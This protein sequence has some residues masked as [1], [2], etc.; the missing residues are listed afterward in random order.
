MAELLVAQR[1]PVSGGA[2][3]S[4][5]RSW[6]F[7][8]D[9]VHL[10][11]GAS[12]QAPDDFSYL[13]D[14]ATVDSPSVVSIGRQI[15]ASQG[16]SFATKSSLRRDPFARLACELRLEI[17]CLLPSLSVKATMLV[18]RSMGEVPFGRRY[19]LSRFRLPEYSHIPEVRLLPPSDNA[20]SP[21]VNLQRFYTEGRY[22]NRRRWLVIQSCH[23]LVQKLLQ[24]RNILGLLTNP[25]IP[26]DVLCNRYLSICEDP[27]AQWRA[28]NK[29]NKWRSL[30]IFDDQTQISR[31][32]KIS[33]S[34]TKS[35]E[36]KLL[37]GIEFQFTQ[38]KLALGFMER[39]SELV[40]DL[41]GESLQKYGALRVRASRFG[42]LSVCSAT[43]VMDDA[44][45]ELYRDTT[46]GADGRKWGGALFPARGNPDPWLPGR[47]EIRGFQ[48]E[49]TVVRSLSRREDYSTD[50]LQDNRIVSLGLLESKTAPRNAADRRIDNLFRKTFVK[51]G[52][53]W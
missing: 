14:F 4:I 6:Y 27:F 48:A 41:V 53:E 47:N 2:Y 31:C 18:S 23:D 8:P 45:P 3:K 13:A 42:F 29:P 25:R 46:V 17:L 20:E 52:L 11:T 33:L 26:D 32:E 37:S 19:W 50:T 36:K 34:F 49:L 51:D 39:D 38:C 1:R 15:G 12:G 16:Q 21:A 7:P 5:E 30:V 40:S 44:E 22:K 10:Y 35:C 9:K 43:H 24:R 28:S